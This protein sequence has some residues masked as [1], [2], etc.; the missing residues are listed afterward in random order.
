M[1]EQMMEMMRQ[2]YAQNG[3]VQQ[4]QMLEMLQ[5]MMLKDTAANDTAG[6]SDQRDA[7]ERTNRNLLNSRNKWKR[8][9]G[10]LAR[11]VRYFAQLLGSCPRC[12]GHDESC[13][14]C[15]GTNSHH[16]G[17]PDIESLIALVLPIFEQSGLT[18]VQKQ[19]EVVNRVKENVDVHTE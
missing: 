13:R 8:H 3:S 17:E 11:T 19:P 9:A 1:N 12:F 14:V 4:N 18:I 2:N 15:T 16:I 5:A 10:Q 6:Q 7:S